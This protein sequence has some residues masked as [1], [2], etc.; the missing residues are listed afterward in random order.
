LEELIIFFIG[1]K[2]RLMRKQ[3]LACLANCSTLFLVRLNFDR[4]VGHEKNSAA[5]VSKRTIP[6]KQLQLV[7]EVSANV[8]G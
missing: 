6:T 3:R 2:I 4:K 1:I 7:D 8:C 5:L